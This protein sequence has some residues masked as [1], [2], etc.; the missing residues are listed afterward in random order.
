LKY[1]LRLK[2]LEFETAV[3]NSK[4]HLIVNKLC[5]ELK[6]LQLKFNDRKLIISASN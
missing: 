5:R 3:G 1:K 6:A 2:K 4:S